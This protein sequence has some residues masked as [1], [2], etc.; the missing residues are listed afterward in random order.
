MHKQG[1]ASHRAANTLRRHWLPATLGQVTAGRK[2][3]DLG[4]TLGPWDAK[5]LRLTYA[6]HNFV[7]CWMVPQL[8][9]GE[10]AMRSKV[11]ARPSDAN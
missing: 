1:N 10:Q 8:R 2:K 4:D 11:G 3:K 6:H 9:R 7:P 5:Y